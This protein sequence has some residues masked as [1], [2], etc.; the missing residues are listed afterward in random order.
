MTKQT[1]ED[2]EKLKKKSLR[3]SIL[4]GS[5]WSIM[6]GAGTSYISPFAIALGA[7]NLQ[8]GFLTSLPNL[9]S[10]IAQYFTV[11]RL[12]SIISR[13]KT[14]VNAV[15]IQALLWLPV[16]LIPF[17]LE[18]F[19]VNALIILFTLIVSAGAFIVPIWASLMG[20]LVNPE[21]RGSYF[22]NRNSISGLTSIVFTTFAGFI[23]NGFASNV[24]YGF[25]IIFLIAFIARLI[26]AYFLNRHYEPE[27]RFPEQGYIPLSHFIKHLGKTNFGKFT[28]YD[29]LTQFATFLAAP[30]FTVYMLRTLEFTYIQYMV[31]LTVATIFSLIGMRFWGKISDWYGNIH[32]LRIIGLLVSLVPLLWILNSNFVFL[33]IVQAIAGFAWGG[34]RITSFDFIY[35]VT[36]REKRPMFMAYHNIVIGLG[37]FFGASIG[38]ILLN[39]YTISFMNPILFIFLVSGILRLTIYVI[40]YKKIKDVRTMKNIHHVHK[41]GHSI[42]MQGSIHDYSGIHHKHNKE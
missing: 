39:F 38:G 30:F 42:P 9:F 41:L 27:F 8:I 4:D 13:K 3:D 11:K 14:I 16:I 19:Q 32:S 15:I 1:K 22:G 29:S 36:G 21:H 37:M 24:F 28:L 2:I 34:F 18:K 17:F 7:S 25:A 23:L 26:S 10:P 40:F 6:E 33:I 5:F 35:D 20:D 12:K 31:I